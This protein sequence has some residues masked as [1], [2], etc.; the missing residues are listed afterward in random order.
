MIVMTMP[1][2]SFGTIWERWCSHDGGRRVVVQGE[3][4]RVC[5]PLLLFGG[6]HGLGKIFQPTQVGRER[7]L[8]AVLG[9]G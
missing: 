6:E 8:Q 3:G 4:G 1:K 2:P 9:S 7:F 5:A